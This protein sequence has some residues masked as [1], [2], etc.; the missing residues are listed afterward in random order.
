MGHTESYE[1]SQIMHIY[2]EYSRTYYKMGSNIYPLQYKY[3]S[4]TCKPLV[5]PQSSMTD[6]LWVYIY[7]CLHVV[8]EFLMK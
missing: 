2:A 6:W 8:T 5:F 7:L 1:N 4:I 3:R